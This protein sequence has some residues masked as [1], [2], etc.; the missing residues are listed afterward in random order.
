MIYKININKEKSVLLHGNGFALNVYLPALISLGIKEI[1]INK[2]S[3]KN[4]NNKYLNKYRE[5]II[6]IEEKDY[7]SR[8][9][10]YTI[11]AVSPAKQ[12]EILVKSQILNNTNILILE[13]PIA[14][15]PIQ[16]IEILKKLDK[17]KI[18]YLINYSFR[19][20]KWFYKLSS[21]IEKVS[22][23]KDLF[24]IWK[25]KAKHFVHKRTTWKRFHEKGGG[26]I[27][28]YGIHLIAI[29]S[30]IGYTSID[31]SNIIFSKDDDLISL[32]CSFKSTK[33]LPRCK[34]KIDSNSS[35]NKF[36]SYYLKDHKKIELFNLEAPFPY[37]EKEI[38]EDP[39]I[40]IIKKILSDNNF[41]YDNFKVIELWKKIEDRI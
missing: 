26:A 1:F 24:I 19:Y 8:F 23:N 41:N 18:N 6:F 17:L 15:S 37:L 29:L 3:T 34:I 28:F 22:I 16:A 13:K 2:N 4:L 5:N 12:Y 21:E 10:S 33:S 38:R 20:A 11:I 14:P 9:F 35:E 32:D 25:F 39:R 40:D 36:C 31:K 30:D 27:R 7:K